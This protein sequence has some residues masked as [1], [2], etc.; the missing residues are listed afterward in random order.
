[1]LTVRGRQFTLN[2]YVAKSETHGLRLIITENF[3]NVLADVLVKPDGKVFVMQA[4]P[5]IRPDWV[6]HYIV[7]DLKCIFGSRMETNCPG[8]ILS[9]THFLIQ[10]SWYKLDLQIVEINTGAQP[11]ELFDET[12][13]GTP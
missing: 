6:E 1:M 4:K 11:P 13:K 9:P 2:G 8:K 5:P 3:G 10:R 12:H 7:A